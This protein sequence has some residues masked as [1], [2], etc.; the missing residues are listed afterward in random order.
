MKLSTRSGRRGQSDTYPRTFRGLIEHAE[1]LHKELSDFRERLGED[2][3]IIPYFVSVK[4]LVVV[5]IPQYYIFGNRAGDFTGECVCG[6]EHSFLVGVLGVAYYGLTVRGGPGSDD[7]K[8]INLQR[9]VR[10]CI[11]CAG[12]NQDRPILFGQ[13]TENEMDTIR[14]EIW[15]RGFQADK[16]D[17]RARID[18]LE[19]RNPER[20]GPRRFSPWIT[21]E[22]G[23]EFYNKYRAVRNATPVPATRWPG[24]HVG[25]PLVIL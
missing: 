5:P 15:S 16:A 14:T 3:N 24:N 21:T 13:H 17:L 23:R 10:L 12:G 9:P 11:E 20:L 8:Q 22:I 7:L 19:T 25:K 1:R 4:S 6:R 2:A 18:A